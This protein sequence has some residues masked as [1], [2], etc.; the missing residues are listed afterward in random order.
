[1]ASLTEKNILIAKNRPALIGPAAMELSRTG[2]FAVRLSVISILFL[3]QIAYNIGEF[4]VSTDLVF[5]LFFS[6]YLLFIGCVSFRF[7]PLMLFLCTAALGC[8]RIP[9]VDSLTSWTSLLLLTAL[10]APYTFR[11]SGRPG[12]DAVQRFVQQTFISAATVLGLISCVQIILVNSGI[13]ELTN[14]HYLLPEQIRSA[15][16]YTY[17]REAGI[18]KANGFFLKESADLSVVMALAII[19]EY[20]GRAR[21]SVLGILTSGLICSFSG[22]GLLAMAAGF[23]LPTSISRIPVT[24]AASTGIVLFTILLY[25]A[26]LPGLEIWLDRLSE[27]AVPGTSSYTRFIAPFDMVERVF[28]Q[29]GGSPWLGAGAGSYLRDMVKTGYN[30]DAA[31]WAKLIYEYGILGFV[32]VSSLMLYRLFSSNLRLEI[33]YF[34]FVTWMVSANVLKP[35]IV[36]LVWMMTLVTKRTEGRASSNISSNVSRLERHPVL[37]LGV[38]RSRRSRLWGTEWRMS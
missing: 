1:M 3:S 17:V 19:A 24:I 27:F 33:C 26:N 4:P 25:S 16:T 22:S 6:M 18:I 11:L 30:I 35:E 10:Y 7:F 21:W 15:G 20:F 29:G 32:L 31:T 13:S 28:D 12:I 34:L 36:F 14:I 38:N 37:P 9:F 2:K 23:L 8:F 5:Y